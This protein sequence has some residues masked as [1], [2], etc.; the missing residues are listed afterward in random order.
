MRAL[1]HGADLAEPAQIAALVATARQTFGAVDILINNA[2]VRYFAPIEAFKPE[3][4]DHALA[5]NL[6]A[7]FHTGPARPA[8]HA[9]AR[10]WPHRQRRLGLR[11]VRHGEPCRLR[12]HQDRADR[13]HPRHRARDGGPEHHLQRHLP[14]HDA[15]AQHRS[16]GWRPRWPSRASRARR[17]SALSSRSRQPSRRFV[18]PGASRRW[19]RLLCGPAGADITGS[20]IPI[21]GGWSAS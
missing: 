15:D 5:V 11:P 20:A 8:R 16:S 3:D 2:V 1:H 19:S 12:H 14:R 6:S 7:A 13:L 4:W 18:D 17:P 9:R 21:D 10:F